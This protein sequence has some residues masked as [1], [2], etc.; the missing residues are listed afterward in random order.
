MDGFIRRFSTKNFPVKNMFGENYVIVLGDFGLLWDEKNS[1]RWVGYLTRWL[2]QKPFKV[3]FVAGN[4]ENYDMLEALPI[5]DFKGGKVGVVSS[6]I[7][8]LKHGYVFDFD[9][10][11][12]GVFGGASSID[13]GHRTEGKTWWKQEIPTIQDMQLFVDN[14]DAVG[15]QI[16]FLLTHTTASDEL[17]Y[18]IYSNYKL[19]DDVTRFIMFIKDQYVIKEQHLFG[20]FHTNKS[21][22]LFKS[23]C[24]YTKILNLDKINDSDEYYYGHNN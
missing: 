13:R 12:V 20:H 18:F 14:L 16:D 9:G 17:P 2:K 8:W 10:K 19:F 24:L 21:I 23:T 22:S 15:G 7:M 1:K 11:K 6:Q 4:H 3:L 5:A